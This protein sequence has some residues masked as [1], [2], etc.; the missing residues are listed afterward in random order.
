MLKKCYT[1]GDD[2]TKKKIENV[3][4]ASQAKKKAEA[5]AMR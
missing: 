4:N 5:G 3:W 1:E 2:D